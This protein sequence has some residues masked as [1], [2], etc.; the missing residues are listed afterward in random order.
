M[1][2]HHKGTKNTRSVKIPTAF[3]EAKQI[4]LLRD[5]FPLSLRQILLQS[6]SVFRIFFLSDNFSKS[7]HK[8]KKIAKPIIKKLKKVLNVILCFDQIFV[9]F[10]KAS[11][12]F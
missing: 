9:L 1:S 2:L 5:T 8:S 6:P 11:V 3:S 7:Q 12:S 10:F 4:L